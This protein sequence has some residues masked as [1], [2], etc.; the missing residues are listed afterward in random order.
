MATAEH[1][2]SLG[3]SPCPNDTFI[4]HALVTGTID[5]APLSFAPP[6][7]EDVETLNRWVLAG[8]FDVSKVSMHALGYLLD[9]YVLLNAGAALGRG[10]GPLLVAA[11][12]LSSSDLHDLRVAI[13]GQYTAAAMLLRLYASRLGA[14][15]AMPFHRIMDAVTSGEVD[16]GVIIHEGRFTYQRHGLQCIQDLGAWWEEETGHPI[17]LGGIVARRSLGTEVLC[18]VEDAIRASVRAAVAMPAASRAYVKCHAQELEDEVVAA[19][20]KLYVNHFSED[21]GPSGQAAITEFLNRGHAAGLFAA[22]TSAGV[23]LTSGL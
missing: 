21:L 15:V 18:Q 13:P 20:I 7:L 14:T 10:C 4:F 12:P 22:P 8:R 11:R 16:A 6:V 19:H 2:L 9:N 1:V 23:F 17:P 3:F 5:T